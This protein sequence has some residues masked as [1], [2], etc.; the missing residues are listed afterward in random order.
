MLCKGFRSQYTPLYAL[1]MA[2]NR[3]A[4]LENDRHQA[5]ALS[6][7]Q[8]GQQKAHHE[9]RKTVE[10]S[11]DGNQGAEKQMKTTVSYLN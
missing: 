1:L 7:L 5:Q 3:E 9:E 11:I 4:M 6:N 8:G 2:D 10:R